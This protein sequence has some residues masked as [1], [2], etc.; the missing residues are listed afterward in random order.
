MTSYKIQSTF[1]NTHTHT[2]DDID[3]WKLQGNVIREAK[4]EREKVV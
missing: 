1:K 3:D 2:Q 4:R